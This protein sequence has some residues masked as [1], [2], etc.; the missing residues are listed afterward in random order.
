MAEFRDF[1]AT[2]YGHGYKGPLNAQTLTVSSYVSFSDRKT[3]S[4][5]LQAVKAGGRSEFT[6]GTGKVRV[7]PALTKLQKSQR[8][9]LDKA[10]SLLRGAAGSQR[11]EVVTRGERC[12][13]VG[14]VVAFEQ[15]K[16]VARGS[17][18]APFTHLS[19][20]A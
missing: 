13:K 2:G 17:F 11:V 4:A 6:L 9:A 12:V 1:R 15:G 7:L 16:G 20:P 5:F 8:W 18:L 19:L 14:G 10:A 3:A